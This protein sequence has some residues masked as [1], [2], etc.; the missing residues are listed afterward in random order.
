[1]TRFVLSPEAA[2]DLAEIWRY[3]KSKGGGAL[4]DRIEAAIR[5]R[6]AFLASNPNVGHFRRDL[7]GEGVKFFP[8]YSWLIVYRE[9]TKPLQVVSILH[10]SR[11]V[12]DEMKGR[13]RDP[14]PH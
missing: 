13:F 4:A 5:E 14:D 3:L 1:M 2:S 9:E 7:T 8:V 10:G 12:E 11:H 6:I